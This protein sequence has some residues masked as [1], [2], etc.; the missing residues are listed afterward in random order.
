[1]NTATVTN[2]AT[3][4]EYVPIN[5]ETFADSTRRRR[6]QHAAAIESAELLAV[7]YRRMASEGIDLNSMARAMRAESNSRLTG[8]YCYGGTTTFTRAEMIEYVASMERIDLSLAETTVDDIVYRGAEFVVDRSAEQTEYYRYYPEHGLFVID[9]SYDARLE[10]WEDREPMVAWNGW[11][12][13]CAS[14]AGVPLT[15]TVKRVQNYILTRWFKGDEWF[16]L[17][18]WN[19]VG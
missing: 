10:D 14:A 1:M 19:M 4:V 9:R 13:D 15:P 11:R 3:V 18:Y 5:V 12:A 6:A 16:Q 17:D 7:D 2:A 8:G